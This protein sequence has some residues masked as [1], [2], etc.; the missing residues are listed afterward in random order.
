MSYSTLLNN[1]YHNNSREIT[2]SLC[3]IASINMME[4]VISGVDDA[5]L[6]RMPTDETIGFCC[7]T[8]ISGVGMVISGIL[9]PKTATLYILLRYATKYIKYA[10]NRHCKSIK[11]N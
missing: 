11:N 6:Y 1:F 10:Y 4:I 9:A 5:G 3:F 7:L 8:T 2:C